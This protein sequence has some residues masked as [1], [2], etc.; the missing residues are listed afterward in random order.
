LP[1][2]CCSSALLEFIP[3]TLSWV[4]FSVSTGHWVCLEGGMLADA[5]IGVKI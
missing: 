4:M 5:A 1:I 3:L 2:I